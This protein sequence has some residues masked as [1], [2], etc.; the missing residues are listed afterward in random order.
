MLGHRRCVISSGRRAALVIG[1]LTLVGCEVPTSTG[2]A[3]SPLRSARPETDE[4]PAVVIEAGAGPAIAAVAVTSAGL[5]VDRDGVL[6][7]LDGGRRERR[8]DRVH[9]KPIVLADGRLVASR[10]GEEAGES[11]LWIS[12]GAEGRWLAPAP[13]ADDD[14]TAL[15]D[16]RVLFVSGRTGVMSVWVVDVQKGAATQLTNVGLVAG[17]SREG[18]VPPPVGPVT[19]VDGRASWDDGYGKR[20]SIALSEE[21]PR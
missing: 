18:F 12:D 1:A 21:S 14:P 10:L 20:W 15:P 11:D 4:V 2:A 6:W 5:V 9:G 19:V 8:L 7:A 17:G 16:G 13:G 3:S